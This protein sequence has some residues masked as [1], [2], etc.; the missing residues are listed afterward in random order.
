V[1]VLTS[2]A[3]RA[4]MLRQASA[5]IASQQ[6]VCDRTASPSR[7]LCRRSVSVR[8]EPLRSRLS[9][10]ISE[11]AS[12]EVPG[13]GA[14]ALPSTLGLKALAS[15]LASRGPR[16]LRI[17]PAVAI[18]ASAA[19]ATLLAY[20]VPRRGHLYPYKGTRAARIVSAR[21][22]ELMRS[23]RGARVRGV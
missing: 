21:R 22:G 5:G 20:Q 2:L 19:A 9:S 12:H 13:F 8:R 17:R 16:R 18:P 10:F 15:A 7:C 23:F 14:P 4:G 3:R 6:A 11:L 1:P